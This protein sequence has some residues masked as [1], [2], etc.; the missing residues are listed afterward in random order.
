MF[1]CEG[2]TPYIIP[3]GGSNEIGTWDYI[4]TFRELIEQ[5]LATKLEDSCMY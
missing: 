1:R 5:V 4:E 2:A 3:A